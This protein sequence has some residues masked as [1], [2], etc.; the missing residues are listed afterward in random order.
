MDWLEQGLKIWL[1]GMVS[2]FLMYFCTILVSTTAQLLKIIFY[3]STSKKLWK[4]Y[5][6]LLVIAFFKGILRVS[7]YWIIDF[8]RVQEQVPLLY[9]KTKTSFTIS[10]LPFSP[11]GR[12]AV[13]QYFKVLG[14]DQG[15]MQKILFQYLEKSLAKID[16]KK[17]KK[18]EINEQE[19]AEKQPINDLITEFQQADQIDLQGKQMA[20]SKINTQEDP[21]PTDPNIQNWDD[22]N[23]RRIQIQKALENELIK[24]GLSLQDPNMTSEKDKDQI[25]EKLPKSTN[26][27]LDQKK[28]NS[29]YQKNKK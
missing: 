13:D 12:Q 24:R 15:E 17:K 16:Q 10:A 3:F 6:F 11:K 18:Q 28:A 14:V 5:I 4:L 29:L 26:Q 8:W 7:L 20:V 21:Q 9:K 25:N 1:A 2:V 19:N 22:L 27:T 23:R